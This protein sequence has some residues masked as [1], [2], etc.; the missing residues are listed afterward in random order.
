MS[1]ILIVVASSGFFGLAFNT[2][3]ISEFS[4]KEACEVALMEAKKEWATRDHE[5]RC[6]SVK[7]YADKLKRKAELE[8]LK[9]ELE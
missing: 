5:S 4:S 8:A 2:N 7:A 3:V 1:Y 6:V 9:G